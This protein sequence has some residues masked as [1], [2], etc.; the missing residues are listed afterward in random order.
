MDRICSDRMFVFVAIMASDLIESFLRLNFVVK[1][2]QDIA[3]KILPTLKLP[4]Q[5]CPKLITMIA[6]WVRDDRL[7][8]VPIFKTA[9]DKHVSVDALRE[10][11]GRQCNYVDKE[12]KGRRKADLWLMVNNKLIG[13]GAYNGKLIGADMADIAPCQL[14]ESRPISRLKK[15]LKREW[16]KGASLMRRQLISAKIKKAFKQYTYEELR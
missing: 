14:V 5:N 3:F 16:T 1:E 12:V 15:K 6:D 8:R 2:L 13:A 10:F 7:S 9:A 4:P 11:L